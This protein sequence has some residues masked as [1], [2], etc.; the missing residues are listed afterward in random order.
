MVGDI[1]H[2]WIND[3]DVSRVAQELGTLT[4]M[5]NK[6]QPYA[7]HVTVEHGGGLVSLRVLLDGPEVLVRRRVTQGA[8]GMPGA[9][10]PRA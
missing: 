7:A 3:D 8:A 2:Y 1:V 9:W 5:P 10:A 4:K 6:G